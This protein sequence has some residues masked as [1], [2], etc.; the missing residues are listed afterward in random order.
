MALFIFLFIIFGVSV[1]NIDDDTSLELIF[2]LIP[3]ND[4]KN[5]D[6]EWEEDFNPFEVDFS[7]R[8]WATI[9]EVKNKDHIQIIFHDNS[10][11]ENRFE[12]IRA[13][14]AKYIFDNYAV[15]SVHAWQESIENNSTQQS[16]NGSLTKAFR[17]DNFVILSFVK[18]SLIFLCYLLS[19]SIIL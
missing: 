15:I 2:P 19:C 11:V 10:Q 12:A 6:V 17:D 5:L 18:N 14:F 7:G 9:K 16:V 3:C 13:K 8:Y 4:G 1:K